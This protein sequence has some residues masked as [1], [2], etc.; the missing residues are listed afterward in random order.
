VKL[1]ASSRDIRQTAT[2]TLGKD[3]VVKKETRALVP[4]EKI[5]ELKAPARALQK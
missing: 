4:K 1:G 5:A 3:T 2:F